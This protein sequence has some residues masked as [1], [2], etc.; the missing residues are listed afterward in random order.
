[1]RKL[2]AL[3]TNELI[4]FLHKPFYIIVAVIIIV[5]MVLVG[6]VGKNATDEII[7]YIEDESFTS[8]SHYEYEMEYLNNDRNY[9][10]DNI[11]SNVKCIS[12]YVTEMKN[13]EGRDLNEIYFDGKIVNIVYDV[14][15]SFSQYYYTLT[16]LQEL[17]TYEKY[18]AY[19]VSYLME[20]AE[21][22]SATEATEQCEN[23]YDELCKDYPVW[24][25]TAKAHN[26]QSLMN[27]PEANTENVA[28]YR[29]IL[30][31]KNYA[32]YIEYQNKLIMENDSL[33]ETTKDLS[34]KA[35]ALKL[36]INPDGTD[37]SQSI[38]ERENAIDRYVNYSTMAIEGI[39]AIGRILTPAQIEEYNAIAAELELAV[40]KGPVGFGAEKSREEETFSQ[41]M[42]SVGMGIASLAV[43]LFAAT[44]ISDEIQSGSI[45][46]L[47]ITP[48][49][50]SKIFL[51]KLFAIMTVIAGYGLVIFSTFTLLNVI[52]GYG[53]APVIF[54]DIT[55]KVSSIG[56]YAYVGFDL[57]FDMI[58][59]F[60]YACFALMLSAL[61][62]NSALSICVTMF[63]Y[64]AISNIV[65]L[66]I[67]SMDNV[68]INVIKSV[69]PEAN[70]SLSEKIFVQNYP[71]MSSVAESFV[72]LPT[73]PDT[74]FWFAA[75]YTAVLLFVLI[76]IGFDSF[77]RRDIK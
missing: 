65:P 41:M 68:T 47:I 61:M 69:I 60:V 21:K 33:S 43:L 46:M 52:L 6:I 19:D 25:E 38:R 2:N 37:N 53:S 24:E 48:V 30:E 36:E 23:F 8:S 51:A 12:D 73:L 39:D 22:I 57:F 58:K 14:A 34:V 26:F 63:E 10:A 59:L 32:K 75:I 16:R 55:G 27:I 77:C 4:K 44:I 76:Y 72:E 35:N 7:Y 15:N 29:E 31:S 66:V 9:Y 45:K 11:K 56:Y 74:A 62:R 42:L 54:T 67:A 64:L 3:Y 28:F 5:A 18:D 71:F 40:K 17:E 70:I 50:R 13:E 49:K 1:M 20:C